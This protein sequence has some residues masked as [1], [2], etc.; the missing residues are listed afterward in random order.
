MDVNPST[1]TPLASCSAVEDEGLVRILHF[2]VVLEKENFA[3]N[4][5]L[6]TAN[7][8]KH[9]GVV[10][11]VHFPTVDNCRVEPPTATASSCS[12]YAA[13]F[14]EELGTSGTPCGFVM[15]THA[16]GKEPSPSQVAI[17][18]SL[19]ADL[20][21]G[22]CHEDLKELQQKQATIPSKNDKISP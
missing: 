10:S 18:S 13:P 3:A 5:N 14:H 2:L 4:N 15:A 12:T 21:L 19:E 20:V 11:T 16:C 9:C 22:D 6:V 8:S 7:I 17:D 1:A